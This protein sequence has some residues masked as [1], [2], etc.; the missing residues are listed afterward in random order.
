MKLRISLI[1]LGFTAAFI[2]YHIM[3]F[4]NFS[5]Y[6]VAFDLRAT[7]GVKP[8]ISFYE[9][10]AFSFIFSFVFHFAIFKKMNDKKYSLSAT[11]LGLSF[12]I[13]I[14]QYV[15]FIFNHSGRVT[16]SRFN[17]DTLSNILT[18]ITNSFISPYLTCL[19]AV[20]F[21]KLS[22]DLVVNKSVE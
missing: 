7:S 16:I 12:Y 22:V 9:E 8:M 5:D 6:L 4:Y 3:I 13:V 21:A 19:I 20:Y 14:L 18:W 15:H 10:A 17:I 11:C 2:G 1:I